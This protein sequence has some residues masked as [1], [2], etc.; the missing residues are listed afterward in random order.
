MRRD[1]D[2]NYIRKTKFY[3]LKDDY[4]DKIIAPENRNSRYSDRPAVLLIVHL[5]F[6]CRKEASSLGA[7]VIHAAHT[8]HCCRC[9]GFLFWFI[10]HS[11]FSSNQNAGNGSRVLNGDTGHF[12]RINYAGL[13]QVFILFSPGIKTKITFFFFY[14]LHYNAA[15]QTTIKN[16]LPERFFHGT[17]NNIYTGC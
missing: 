2:R 12:C 16:D 11:T 5:T 6:H 9:T 13:I 15:V 4:P 7:L 10:C 14:F 8:W 3:A 1:K 17:F